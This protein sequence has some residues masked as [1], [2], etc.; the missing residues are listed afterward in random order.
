MNELEVYGWRSQPSQRFSSSRP[1]SL[2]MRSSSDGHAYL[3]GEIVP[4]GTPGSVRLAVVE[5]N[6]SEPQAGYDLK[7]GSATLTQA[8]IEQ[9]RANLPSGHQDIPVTEIRP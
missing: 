9:I 7:T 8:R 2:A 5:G 1:A 3:D 4:Y 6:I